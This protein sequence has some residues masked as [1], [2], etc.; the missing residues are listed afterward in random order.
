[1]NDR[2]S[3]IDPLS[4]ET[5]PPSAA[6]RLFELTLQ[7]RP[8][9]HSRQVFVNRTLRMEKITTIGF[10]LDWTLADYHQDH[11][12]QLAFEMTLDRLIAEFDYPREI[13]G[14]EYRP[15]FARRGLML[16]TEAGTVLKMNRHRYVGR[17]YHGRRFLDRKERAHLY[18]RE[19]IQPGSDR[20]YFVDTLFELPEVSLFSELIELKSGKDKPGLPSYAEIFRDTRKAVDSIHADGSLKTRILSDL[21]RYLPRDPETV[22]ALRRLALGGRRL[23]LITNSEQY[24]TDALC[25][26]LFDGALPGLDSWRDLFD[27]VIV[28]SRK[29][30]FFRKNVPFLDLSNGQEVALPEWGGYYQGGCRTGLMN[31]LGGAGEEVVYVGDHIYGDILS[32]KQVSTWRTALVV[33]ELEEE[34][35]AQQGLQTK[36]RHVD[37]L[38][39]ELA[40]SGRQMDDVAD[41]LTLYQQIVVN[42]D[43]DKAP[44]DPNLARVR[45]HFDLLKQDHRVMRH[46]KNRLQERISSTLNP[47]WGSIFRQGSNKSLFGSQVDDFACVY[48]SRVSNLAYYGRNHY[49]R[50]LRDQMMHDPPI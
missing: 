19:P 47:Y 44:E 25:S 31:L 1:M 29:P 8:P 5:I 41:L 7:D 39:S 13:L 42:G 43:G 26:H 45:E 24:Y 11:L 2:N 37:V 9:Q 4:L 34:L 48:T 40:E 3:L 22:L 21:P 35:E 16:D 17:A 36:S 12:S 27:V 38:R 15:D 28:E 14:A 20:F 18:R 46:H 23:L 50:V 10:D 30:K 49:F 32:S 33:R 6:R